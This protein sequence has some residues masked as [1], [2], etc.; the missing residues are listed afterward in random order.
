ME[1]EIKFRFWDGKMHILN[2]YQ[3]E[4]YDDYVLREDN[5]ESWIDDHCGAV[6]RKLMQ[7]T[8]L[9]DKNG[10]EIY[11]GDIC[12]VEYYNH[13][14]PNTFIK[15]EVIYEFGTFALKS[16]NAFKLSLKLEDTRQYVPLHW[17]LSPNK[18]EVIGN[19]Y[20]NPQLGG[21]LT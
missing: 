4:S 14:S 7:Y 21:N 15:Q 6:K 2:L 9:R 17:A 20:E 16:E 8:G 11:E 1:R 10:K 19:I 12:N 3:T 18:I 13:S 5:R